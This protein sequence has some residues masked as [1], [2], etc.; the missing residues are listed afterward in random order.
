MLCG[1][2]RS[3]ALASLCVQSTG[4]LKALALL[5][6]VMSLSRYSRTLERFAVAHASLGVA[7][8]LFVSVV[9]SLLGMCKD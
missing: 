3:L 6:C 8:L 7:R 4:L 2:R 5:A 1:L 9:R